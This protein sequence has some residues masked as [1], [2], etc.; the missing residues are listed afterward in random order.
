MIV[1]YRDTVD[2]S[3]MF[4]EYCASVVARK[5]LP[6]AVVHSRNW[7]TKW[8]GRLIDEEKVREDRDY[9]ERNPHAAW[10]KETFELA[11][12]QYGRIDYGVKD[13]IPQVWE[14]NTN[15]MIVRP[16]TWAPNSLTP[17]QR[18]LHAPIR[19]RFLRAFQHALEAVDSPLDASRTVGVE[20]SAKQRRNL[21]AEKRWLRWGKHW[22]WRTGSFLPQPP[23]SLSSPPTVLGQR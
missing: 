21:K 7:V 16:A 14:I 19:T 8:S 17:E 1:E 23:R 20:V 12:V 13:G 15:P 18:S 6:Q 4:R 9:A 5:I 11:H 2:S 10:V 3:G 22:D